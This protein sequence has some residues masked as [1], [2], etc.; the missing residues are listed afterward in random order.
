MIY[1]FTV[2]MN[3]YVGW[4]KKQ[5][6]ASPIRQN[7]LPFIQ[8]FQFNDQADLSSIMAIRVSLSNAESGLMEIRLAPFVPGE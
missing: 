4:K 8:G 6:P 3:K 5:D 7:G 2:A 1:R